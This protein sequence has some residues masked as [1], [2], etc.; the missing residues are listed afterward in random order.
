MTSENIEAKIKRL[1][2]KIKKTYYYDE[3]VN[4]E[5][6]I[7]SEVFSALQVNVSDLSGL[8]FKVIENPLTLTIKGK[9]LANGQIIQVFEFK[10]S[11]LKGGVSQNEESGICC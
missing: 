3:A 10:L 2:T 11:F 5:E 7:K 6:R 8:S 9:A 1:A 4:M